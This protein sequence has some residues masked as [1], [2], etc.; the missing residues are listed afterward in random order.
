MILSLC[1]AIFTSNTALMISIGGLIGHRLALNKALATLPVSAAIVGVALGT[2]PASLFMK[3]F[4]RRPGF[5]IGN[6]IGILGALVGAAGLLTGSFVL[7]TLGSLMQGIFNAHGQLYRFAAADGVE[8][9]LRSKAIS[10]VLAGGVAAGFL[11]PQIAK[12]TRTALEIEFLGAYV[13]SIGLL[14]L[15]IALVSFLTLPPPAETRTQGEE[16]PLRQIGFQPMFVVAALSGMMGFAMMSLIM[17]GTPLAMVGHQL[18]FND[19]AWVIQWHVVAMY[20]PSFFTGALITRFGVLR[21]ILLGCLLNVIAVAIGLMGMR[22]IH[23]WGALVLLG[24]G[25]NFMFIGGSALV[26]RTYRASERP[27]SQAM[28]DFLVFGATAVASLSSGQLL[29]HLGWNAVLLASLPMASLA[30]IATLLLYVR[31]GGNEPAPIA[32]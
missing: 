29:H 7:V 16:R 6:L 15:A 2:I 22:V 23:F 4:G 27:K 17:T 30:L 31:L 14:L 20:L 25:W 21:V 24:L 18:Q 1:Q 8:E 5:I 19:A 9:P 3:R 11:G 32:T 28:N 13:A 10:L 12:W 26:T